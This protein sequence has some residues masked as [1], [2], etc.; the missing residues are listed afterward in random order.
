LHIFPAD[1][2]LSVVVILVGDP[3]LATAHQEILEVAKRPVLFQQTVELPS[4][5][6]LGRDGV[7]PEVKKMTILDNLRFLVRFTVKSFNTLDSMRT[8][9]EILRLNSSP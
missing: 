7:V 2:D 1:G 8:S 5:R 4:F 6:G 3:T 9:T